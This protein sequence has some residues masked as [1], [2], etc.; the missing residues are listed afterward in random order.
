MK[1]GAGMDYKDGHVEREAV[2]FKPV[3]SHSLCFIC[4]YFLFTFIFLFAFNLLF[5][6]T[7]IGFGI[8]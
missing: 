5:I 2:S 6:L 4:L 7:F 1:R 8:S 3:V